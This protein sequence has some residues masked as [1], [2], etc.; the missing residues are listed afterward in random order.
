MFSQK[1]FKDRYEAIYWEDCY[2]KE[3]LQHKIEKMKRGLDA[4]AGLI[5]DSQGVSGL[6]LN[7]DMASWDEL[8]KGGEY[9]TWLKDFDEALETCKK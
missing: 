3:V 8:R 4:V 1:I 6:H 5:S 2:T 9:E 7:G